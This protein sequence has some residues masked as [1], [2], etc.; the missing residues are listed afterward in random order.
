[1]DIDYAI[2]MRWMVFVSFFATL[3]LLVLTAGYGTLVRQIRKNNF[4]GLNIIFTDEEKSIKIHRQLARWVATATVISVF[5]TE[6][7][8]STIGRLSHNWF[9]WLHLSVAVGYVVLLI[10]LLTK[11][12]GLKARPRVHK[13]LA[14]Y[15]I[16]F[17]ALTLLTGL[18]RL[19]PELLGNNFSWL[20][21]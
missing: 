20:L 3:V 18:P 16:T 15:C 17:Y 1:M 7:Y 10:L 6:G 11:F 8:A 19:F 14:Y 13:K 2:F 9:F 21:E 5:L 4:Q 12:T